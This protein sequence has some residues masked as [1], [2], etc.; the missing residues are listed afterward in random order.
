MH[1]WS[2]QIRKG[3]FSI[4]PVSC[5]IDMILFYDIL[6]DTIFFRT[7][8]MEYH[9]PDFFITMT[10]N[11]NWEE[12]KKELLPDQN[13]EDRPN[14]VVAVFKQKLD[15]LMNDLIKGGILGNVAA[16][17]YVV[18]FQK[19]GLPHVHLLL[20]LAEND[21][22]TTDEQVDAVICAELPPDPTIAENGADKEQMLELENIVKTLL[23]ELL[24][25]L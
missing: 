5:P 13:P 16:Y 7:Y 6:K 4:Q 8:K 1:V 2:L 15:A 21:R 23:H 11:P 10:C 3:N 22:L 12:I 19:R 9:K 24:K 20:I 17:Q 14:I 25:I 18:E